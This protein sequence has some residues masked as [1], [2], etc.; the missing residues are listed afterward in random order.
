MKLIVK[1]LIVMIVVFFIILW[2][3]NNDDKKHNRTRLTLFE[4]YKLPLLVSTIV[5]LILHFPLFF[6]IQKCPPENITEISILT[7]VKEIKIPTMT[8][9][10]DIIN[11]LQISTDMP[12]F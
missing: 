12:D 3:Q 6:K 10:K 8:N 5:G 2:F 7:P 11:N 1:Q 9:L 4:K